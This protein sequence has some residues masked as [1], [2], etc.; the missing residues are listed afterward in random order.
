MFKKLLISLILILSTS[1]IANAFHPLIVDQAYTNGQGGFLVDINSAY[2]TKYSR[3]ELNPEFSLGVIDRLD[4]ILGFK[5]DLSLTL[6]M[7]LDLKLL[8]Y[9]NDFF[10]VSIKPSVGSSSLLSM[11][12]GGGAY[13]FN[14][15]AIASMDMGAFTI[16]ENLGYDFM[17]NA[18]FLSSAGVYK[19]SETIDITLNLGT[20]KFLGGDLFAIGGLIFALSD[21]V[22]FDLG[23]KY[24]LAGNDI[25]G[26]LGLAF[27][28]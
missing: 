3:V 27:K 13:Y 1:S 6:G 24:E 4:V 2:S 10:A 15:F 7:N 22:F 8:L 25:S 19:A 9:K 11:V 14:L 20:R 18:I 16:H 23:V 12:L 28:F 26:L 17:N 21:N 5:S